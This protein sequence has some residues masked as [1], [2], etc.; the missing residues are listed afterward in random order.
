MRLAA[1]FTAAILAGSSDNERAMQMLKEWIF[2]V[3]RH[4][5]GERDESLR[6]IGAWTAADLDVMH[7]YFEAIAEVP[8]DNPNRA[9]RR[10]QISRF[11]LASIKQRT[12]DLRLRGDFDDFRKRA[13]ILHTDAALLQSSPVVVAPPTPREKRPAWRRGEPEPAVDVL[14]ADGRVERFQIENPHWQIAK[15]LLEALPAKPRRDPIVA[16]WYRAIAAHF[17]REDNRAD[18]LRHFEWAHRVVPDDPG[19]LFGEACLQETLGSPNVQNFARLA[20]LP[21]GMVILGVT[22]PQ[23][24]FRR[25]ETLLE[26][27]LASQPDFVEARLRLGHVLVEQRQ[28]EAALTQL[29]EVIASTSDPLLGYY[30]QLF[31]GDAALALNR[32]AESRASYER[33][34]ASHPD[35]QAARL[36]LAAATRAAG[37]RR[38]AIDALMITL[39]SKIERRDSEHDPWWQY[40]NGDANNVDRLLS[41]LRA[42]FRKPSR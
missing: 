9:A 17:A 27:A 38:G 39:S 41:E 34:L 7:A 23:N 3:D 19:V 6:T 31:S 33:A 8:V 15:N 37:D 40:Y 32:I 1:L 29:G 5:A 26:R 20:A 13:A 36:G 2:A 16:Q 18:A 12:K 21:N 28:Y 35:A 10:R 11:D 30:A 4:A 25:A 42:P 22:S 14:S 24:H